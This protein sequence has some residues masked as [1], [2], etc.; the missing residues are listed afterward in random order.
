MTRRRRSCS[1]LRAQSK[2][3]SVR[4]Q[5]WSNSRVKFATQPAAESTQDA[6]ATLRPPTATSSQVEPELSPFGYAPAS[7]VR[8]TRLCERA[9][10]S[11]AAALATGSVRL[12]ADPLGFAD[13]S[14]TDIVVIFASLDSSEFGTGFCA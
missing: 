10:P 6:L 3:A 4:L 12:S 2:R 5:K 7:L 9:R 1:C 8:F 13:E 11:K 14:R